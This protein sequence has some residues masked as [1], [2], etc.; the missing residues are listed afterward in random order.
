MNVFIRNPNKPIPTYYA[1]FTAPDP[2]RPGKTKRYLRNT[3]QT[4]E[5]KARKV[6][7]QLAGAANAA[8]LDVLEFTKARHSTGFGQILTHHGAAA[9]EITEA[10][11]R[12]DE[13]MT[14]S[15]AIERLSVV[16]QLLNDASLV[17][18]NV[19]RSL[20]VGT[21]PHQHAEQL[22]ED[23]HRTRRQIEQ[24]VRFLGQHGLAPM[25]NAPSNGCT[26]KQKP[27]QQK[28]AIQVAPGVK[29]EPK[30]RK[31]PQ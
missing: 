23:L 10:A 5:E 28:S 26:S 9:R 13:P 24:S 16:H 22:E 30:N 21:W 8:R 27:T 17:A 18:R 20:P 3:F 15:Q 11:R 29:D 2:E 31:E 12:P 1:R 19:R 25:P 7:E 14:A 4:T 6:L